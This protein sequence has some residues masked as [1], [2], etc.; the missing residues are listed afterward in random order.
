MNADNLEELSSFFD[1]FGRY[2]IATLQI[3]PVMDFE[4]EY[5][6]LLTPDDIQSYRRIISELR[7]KSHARGIAFLSNTTDPG[8]EQQ[9]YSSLILQAVHRRITPL[10]VWREDFD[11]RH[12]T[13]DDFCRRIGWAGFLF[14]TMFTDRDK[15]LSFNTGAWGK[16]SAKYEVNI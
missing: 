14:R 3:R 7:E 1:V 8:F 16:H 11:W 4:G 2:N 6:R 10:S 9:N 5:R 12:E 15:A 13:Y